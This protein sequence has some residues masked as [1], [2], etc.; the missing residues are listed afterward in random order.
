MPAGAEE[1]F[2]AAERSA[3]NPI[4]SP[5]I[6]DTIG[7]N[8]NGPSLIR[9][10]DWLDR[11][12]GRYYLYFAHHQGKFIRLAY[13]DD[14]D[15][16]WRIYRPGT[17]HIDQTI[18]RGHIAS[19]DVHVDHQRRRIVMYFHGCTD[20]GQK[21]F[22]A[23]SADGLSFRASKRC[24]GPSYFRVFTHDGFYYAVAKKEGPDGGGVLLRSRDGRTP[25]EHGPEIIP[26]MRHAAVLKQRS[27]L[28]IF[29]SRGGDCPERILACRMDL[30]GDWRRWK[31]GEP[32]EV[33]APEADYEGALL[34]LECSRFGAVHEPVRQLRD[35]AVFR[36]DGKTYLVYSCAGES[37]LGIA[38]LIPKRERRWIEV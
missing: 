13:A 37:G 25:F 17:L 34:P 1:H 7:E 21:T 19:P 35:P 32:F 28:T 5:D 33:L 3:R 2:Y 11:P 27:E 15:G 14:L 8:I 26:R 29:F 9:V 24:L 12:L 20:D 23:T 18:C 30:R 4:I 16:P 10:P 31:P 38:E 22:H 36:E 6:D